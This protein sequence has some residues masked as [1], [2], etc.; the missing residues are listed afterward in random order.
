MNFRLS[1]MTQSKHHNIC[2]NIIYQQLQTRLIIEHIHNKQN[3]KGQSN[4]LKSKN[5]LIITE[6]Y[7]SVHNHDSEKINEL[8]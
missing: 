1:N 5:G 8:L 4:D 6:K 3:N 7:V 2:V